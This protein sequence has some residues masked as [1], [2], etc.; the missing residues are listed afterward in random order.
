MCAGAGQGNN[1][2]A[3]DVIGTAVLDQTWADRGLDAWEESRKAEDKFEEREV[4][5]GALMQWA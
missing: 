1:R 4:G 2:K 5:V 3:G